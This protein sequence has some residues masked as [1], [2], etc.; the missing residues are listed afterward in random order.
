MRGWSAGLVGWA[1]SELPDPGSVS[2]PGDSAVLS[3]DWDLGHRSCSTGTLPGSWEW[4]SL[5]LETGKT[6]RSGC[7]SPWLLSPSSTGCLPQQG[8]ILL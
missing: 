1:L 3:Q 6:G 5:G 7:H 8:L 4:W 2:P